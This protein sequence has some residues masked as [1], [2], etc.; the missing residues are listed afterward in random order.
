VIATTPEIRNAFSIT[1]IMS[2]RSIVVSELAEE[3]RE[4]LVIERNR[5]HGLSRK[6]PPITTFTDWDRDARPGTAARAAR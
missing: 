3:H 6:L 4:V 1:S 5:G 2:G